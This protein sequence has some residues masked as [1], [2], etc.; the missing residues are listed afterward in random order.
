MK[1]PLL[2]K[3]TDAD[4]RDAEVACRLQLV[5]G[6]VSETSRVDGKGFA[7]HK[8]HTEISH[9]IKS[10]P[11]KSAM[12]PAGL[13]IGKTPCLGKPV[14]LFLDA[15]IGKNPLHFFPRNGLKKGPGVMGQLPQNRIEL[16]PEGVGRMVPGPAQV[17]RQT[18]QTVEAFHICMG[19]TKRCCIVPSGRSVVKK[20]HGS[21]L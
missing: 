20:R 11:G 3:K 9:M 5:T 8:L 15:W 14:Q 21:L 19:K 2:I 16:S 13:E 6:D 1:I 17:Q 4:Y 18:D 10:G 12:K 7:Q